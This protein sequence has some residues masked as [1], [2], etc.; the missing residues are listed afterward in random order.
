[1]LIDY[2]LASE[3]ESEK[4]IMER[5]TCHDQPTSSFMKG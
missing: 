5:C 4:K 3:K 2:L 1:M